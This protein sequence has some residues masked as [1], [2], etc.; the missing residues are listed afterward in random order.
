[1]KRLLPILL[2]LTLALVL[3]IR[4]HACGCPPIMIHSE[5]AAARER[6]IA[7]YRG[8]GPMGL[9]VLLKHRDALLQAGKDPKSQEMIWLSEGIDA[10]GGA[11]YCTASRLYWYTDLD[12]ARQA[13]TEEGK[14]ILSLRMLG[15]LTDDLSCANSRFFR[16]TLYANEEI[17]NL[18]RKKFV[19]HWQS[20]RP[21]PKIT[22]DFGDGRKLERT[23]TGNSAHYV[24]L[25]DGTVVDCLPGL[26]G[27][28]AFK[29]KLTELLKISEA[30]P[31]DP[32]VRREMLLAFH[33]SEEA[34]IAKAL[35]ADLEKIG[36][37]T[38]NP[39]A[40][41]YAVIARA[42]KRQSDA[43]LPRAER[44]APPAEAAAKVAVPKY[45]AERPAIA[46][47][48]G[49]PITASADVTDEL[50]QKLAAL[51]AEDARLDQSS[52]TLIASHNPTAALA[53]A[54]AIT[55]ARIES[56]LVRMFRNLEQSVAIDTVRNE[57]ELHRKL[58]RWFVDGTAP[59]DVEALNE[60]VY[61]EL[62]LTPKSDPWLGLLTSD[63]YSALPNNGVIA[64]QK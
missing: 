33:Q 42:L 36:V 5:D 49:K 40:N 16:T 54:L 12:Q 29:E 20:V 25:A 51:H 27:P 26:Y 2:G 45:V 11:K 31:E 24:L 32:S 56:P 63:A 8:Y 52:R 64:S 57:Y 55:K 28:K 46:A 37:A 34:R 62:F 9:E 6:A 44:V 18:L 10:V 23:I 15:K 3:A 19:L 50:W 41:S 7:I 58:H 22:I 47:V 60:R 13:A 30:M 21:V 35:Q 59:A 61:A 38:A 53:G 43:E 39:P 4:A 14:P 1:M 48:T 17:S